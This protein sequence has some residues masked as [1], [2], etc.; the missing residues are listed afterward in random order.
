MVN[1]ENV[2]IQFVKTTFKK[3]HLTKIFLF[4]LQFRPQNYIMHI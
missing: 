1:E 4:W 2:F 3:K